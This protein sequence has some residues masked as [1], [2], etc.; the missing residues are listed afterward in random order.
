MDVTGQLLSSTGSG[1]LPKAPLFVKA[2]SSTAFL[3]VRA[4]RD[5]P[6]P[7]W[8]RCPTYA[9]CRQSSQSLFV[10]QTVEGLQL[11]GAL[12]RFLQA[13]SVLKPIAPWKLRASWTSQRE[14][15]GSRD[16]PS[17]RMYLGKCYH[18]RC[19]YAITKPEK[20]CEARLIVVTD[21][22]STKQKDSFDLAISTHAD[23]TPKGGMFC[24][25]FFVTP[26]AAVP[27]KVKTFPPNLYATVRSPVPARR[28]REFGA[29]MPHISGA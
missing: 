5:V 18:T 24:S 14:A 9:T 16:W 10:A 4:S 20:G 28:A 15:L 8:L 27:R 29:P 23:C 25:D 17:L 12:G 2:R 13:H 3:S 26:G 11:S 19:K 21:Q 7:S 6:D 1:R 22:S